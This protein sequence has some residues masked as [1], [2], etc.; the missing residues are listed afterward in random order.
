MSQTYRSTKYRSTEV[1]HFCRKKA[2]EK[3]GRIC[4]NGC[5]A[6]EY[7]EHTDIHAGESEQNTAL[8]RGLLSGVC[9]VYD[10]GACRASYCGWS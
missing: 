7:R 10:I 8:V 6:Y 1:Q 9:L 2:L 4:Y 5:V 3:G